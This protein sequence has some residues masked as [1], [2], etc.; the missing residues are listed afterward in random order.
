MTKQ[1]IYMQ[2]SVIWQLFCLL[3]LGFA[4]IGALFFITI[5]FEGIEALL[6]GKNLPILSWIGVELIFLIVTIGLLVDFF[7]MESTTIIL[8]GEKIWMRG[9]IKPKQT[10]IQY[11]VSV[12]LNEITEISIIRTKYHDSRGQTLEGFQ[13]LNTKKY[14]VFKKTDGTES[15]ML[16]TNYTKGYLRKILTDLVEQIK[17]T[18]E[19]YNGE[20]AQEILAKDR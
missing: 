18:S 17:K 3:A 11:K 16:I 19:V 15:W 7:N 8:D 20:G 2:N 5:T 1:K 6:A 9:E 10:K 13:T 12:R 14:L 4:T